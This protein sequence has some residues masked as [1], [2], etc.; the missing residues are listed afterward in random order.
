MKSPRPNIDI[1]SV[2]TSLK[3]YRD[4]LGK[5]TERHHYANEIRLV[6]YAVTGSCKSDLDINNPSREQRP[7]LREVIELN[8]QLIESHIDYKSRK[9]ACRELVLNHKFFD[10]EGASNA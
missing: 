9:L 10:I 8:R 6:R 1:G 2:Q 5:E 3:Q 4:S 7:A